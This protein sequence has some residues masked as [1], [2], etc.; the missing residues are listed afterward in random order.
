[1]NASRRP[2]WLAIPVLWLCAMVTFASP[3]ADPL[4][5]KAL[6]VRSISRCVMLGAA[7]AGT[8]LVAVGERG[9]ITL[10]DDAGRTWRQARHVPVSVTLTAVRFVNGQ[11]GWATGHSG[12]LLHTADGGENWSRQLDGTSLAAIARRDAQAQSTGGATEAQSKL[13]LHEADLLARDGADK[14]LLDLAFSDEQN[15]VVVGAYNLVFAT[16][17]GGN[18]WHSWMPRTGNSKALHLYAVARQGNDVYIAGE[19]GLLLRSGDAG[20]TFS[21]VTVP[22]TGSW[23]SLAFQPDHSLIVVGLKGNAWRIGAAGQ[24]PKRLT[25]GGA[26]AFVS[27]M[28]NGDDGMLLA[29]QNGELFAVASTDTVLRA[30]PVE[31]M[32]PLSAV[33]PLA[34]NRGALALTLQGVK[35][36]LLTGG[37]K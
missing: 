18:T 29:A 6:Q 4:E 31:P 33:V 10:S 26:A 12:V 34:Q 24:A 11:S 17:D 25:G 20:R 5:R 27:V 19:Q 30:L 7:R 2:R 35:L 28:R 9:V 3:V 14:P 8:R 37:I 16:T 21:P 23:F 32:P 36:V 22:Y 13:A 15:G 1:M